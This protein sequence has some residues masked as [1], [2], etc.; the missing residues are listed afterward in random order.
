MLAA[1]LGLPGHAVLGPFRAMARG[2][3]RARRHGNAWNHPHGWGIVYGEGARLRCHRSARPCWDDPD[4]DAFGKA[5]VFLLHAR[6]ATNGTVC[7][8]NA[9]PFSRDVDGTAWFF[10]H[11][12][13]VRDPLPFPEERADADSTDSYRLFQSLA[14]EDL[15]ASPGAALRSAY[16]GLRDFTSLNTFLLGDRELWAVCR[17]MR[18]EAY[19]TLHL[20]ESRG[21]PLVSSEPLDGVG[22]T[23]TSLPNGSVLRVDR[24]TGA[25]ERQ[26]LSVPS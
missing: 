8:E 4:F 20:G 15:R 16:G 9:H 13:T 1:P 25:V 2:E 5:R 24:R 17:W 12:G 18:D 6:K 21:G 19:Y 22:K 10:C 26:I 23:W 7:A 3:N 14:S 11:N